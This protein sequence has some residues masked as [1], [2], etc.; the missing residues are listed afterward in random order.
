MANGDRLLVCLSIRA[1]R[2]QETI[3][4]I[5]KYRS[6]SA[7]ATQ[8]FCFALRFHT[9]CL[10]NT[11]PRLVA[12]PVP[13][14]VCRTFGSISGTSACYRARFRSPFQHQSGK[15]KHRVS[16]LLRYA[17]GGL[18]CSSSVRAT[19]ALSLLFIHFDFCPRPPPERAQ[20]S[21]STIQRGR[22]N[23]EGSTGRFRQH[24]PQRTPSVVECDAVKLPV[25]GPKTGERDWKCLRFLSGAFFSLLFLLL[26][27]F[28][29]MRPM[30]VA[31]L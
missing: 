18:T 9:L 23:V 28:I 31:F 25:N 29:S 14:P 26:S 10:E 5:F 19:K 22:L 6:R 3:E 24:H 8:C 20:S 12:S 13:E 11:S 7:S 4:T 17:V 16:H 1:L 27:I 30:L 15:G 2:S 21:R